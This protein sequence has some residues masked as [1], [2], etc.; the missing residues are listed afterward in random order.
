M[1]ILLRASV[2]SISLGILVSLVTMVCAAV[3]LLNSPTHLL[4][5][6]LWSSGNVTRI[7]L[8]ASVNSG[9]ASS[10]L[11]C[12]LYLQRVTVRRRCKGESKKTQGGVI[13]AGNVHCQKQRGGGKLNR[14]RGHSRGRDRGIAC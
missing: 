5:I 2:I 3:S 6:S 11:P 10:N 8:M 13:N 7:A 9:S 1:F 4:A 12:D 14:D